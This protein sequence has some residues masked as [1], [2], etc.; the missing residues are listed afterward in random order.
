MTIQWTEIWRLRWPF[1]F[2]HET[3]AFQFTYLFT[4]KN[5]HLTWNCLNATEYWMTFVLAGYAAWILLRINAVNLAKKLQFQRLCNFSSSQSFWPTYNNKGTKFFC[6]FATFRVPLLID[7]RPIP[8]QPC[9]VQRSRRP[10]YYYGYR[11]TSRQ[12][13]R[14]VERVASEENRLTAN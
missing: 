6:Y 3:R 7:R 5:A 12:Q 10:Y 14:H 8:S 13:T 11:E 1:V 4:L 2:S 9:N